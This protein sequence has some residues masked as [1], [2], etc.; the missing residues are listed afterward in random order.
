[1]PTKGGN[2]LY[3]RVVIAV[4]LVTTLVS[5]ASRRSVSRH[6]GT[7]RRLADRCQAVR[8][9]RP[10]GRMDMRRLFRV[11][12]RAARFNPSDSEPRR[13]VMSALVTWA[14]EDKTHDAGVPRTTRQERTDPGLSTAIYHNRESSRISW[15][16]P[17]DCV[18]PYFSLKAN[19]L[20]HE[21]DTRTKVDIFVCFQ[22]SK[23]Y[24]C[25]GV[26]CPFWDKDTSQ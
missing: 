6:H 26:L 19:I 8:R 12:N 2:V 24:K 7:D 11:D 5:H 20:I 14:D 25:R 23:C 15:G 1:M 21:W 4:S 10:A 22:N 9:I 17:K 18:V 13:W 16:F 3:T